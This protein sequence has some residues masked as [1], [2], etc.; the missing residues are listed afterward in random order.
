LPFRADYVQCRSGQ[1]RNQLFPLALNFS[2][3]IDKATLCK[4]EPDSF[5]AHARSQMVLNIFIRHARSGK[6]LFS[7][8]FILFSRLSWSQQKSNPMRLHG[9]LSMLPSVHLNGNSAS[10]SSPQHFLGLHLNCELQ[11]LFSASARSG[12]ILLKDFSVLGASRL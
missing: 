12:S 4:T 8:H 5:Q 11:K 1:E 7:F 9:A 10:S 3:L 2:S 6:S